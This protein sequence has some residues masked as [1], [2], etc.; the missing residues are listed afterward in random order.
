MLLCVCVC[1]CVCVCWPKFLKVIFT[2]WAAQVIRGVLHLHILFICWLRVIRVL[3]F[4]FWS[5]PSWISW[6]NRGQGTPKWL[7]YRHS[8][9][10]FWTCRWDLPVS[11]MKLFCGKNVGSTL[12]KCWIIRSQTKEILPYYIVLLYLLPV[13]FNFPIIRYR[14]KSNWLW[15]APRMNNNNKKLK[16]RGLSPRA[17][18]TDR[19]A[20]AGRRI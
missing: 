5:L 10:P 13:A 2:A 20:A 6:C 19:A 1:V 18:Y 4:V 11:L 7:M 12:L 8:C 14:Y 16:L 15:H 17:N 3:F 9:R